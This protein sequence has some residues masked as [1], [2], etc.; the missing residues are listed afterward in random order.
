MTKRKVPK[1][2]KKRL[3]FSAPIAIF[4][5]GYCI[6]TLVTTTINLYN[7]HQEEKELNEKLVN[8]KADA[9]SLKTEITKLQDEEYIA[10]YAVSMQGIDVIVFTAGIGENQINIRKGICDYLKFMGVEIDENVNNCRGEEVEIS[11]AN[12]KIKVFV[13][14]T[15]EE[16]MI[17]RD[18][19]EILEKM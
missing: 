7:L 17:A 10:R 19:K 11:T 18:T 8:L 5:I 14:P 6:F 4:I 15:D 1:K 2:A 3:L 13:I 9:K 16:L 12:S